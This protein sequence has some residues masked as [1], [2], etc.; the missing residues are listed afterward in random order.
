MRGQINLLMSLQTI[1]QQLREQEL[2]LATVSSRISELRELIEHSNNELTALETEERQ[3]ALARKE[4]ERTLA[5]GEEQIRIKRMK[6]YAVRNDKEM[7]ALEHEVTALKESNQRLESEVLAKMEAAETS[8]PRIKELKQLVDGKSAELKAAEKEVAGQI[9]ELKSGLARRRV[10]RDAI[11]A[12]IPAALRQRY[13][14]IF[15]RRGGIAVVVAK[16]GTCQGCRMRIPPQLY[17]E[18]QKNLQIHFCPNCQRI[19]YFEAT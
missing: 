1:D 5:D 8:G 12:Q 13:D 15:N 16:A 9:E 4:L 6:L 17:N 18:I 3:A 14:T 7:Q 10:E 19:L 2:A 11:A